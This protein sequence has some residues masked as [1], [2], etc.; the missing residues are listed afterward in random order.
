M[1][2]AHRPDD[3]PTRSVRPVAFKAIATKAPQNLRGLAA[4]P[5]ASVSWDYR[6][7]T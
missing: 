2:A 6:E 5:H 7:F 3:S 1:G 4:K